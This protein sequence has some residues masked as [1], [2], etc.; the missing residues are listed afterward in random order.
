MN[1]F[2]KLTKREDEMMVEEEGWRGK[3]KREENEKIL[4]I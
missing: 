1:T 4:C 3:R 2:Q